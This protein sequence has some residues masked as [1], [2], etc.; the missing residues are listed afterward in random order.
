M[1]LS[2]V[3]HPDVVDFL[4]THPESSLKRSVWQCLEKLKKRQFDGGLRVKKLKGIAKGVWEAR[5]NQANRLT[6]TYEK[7][8]QPATGEKQVYLA[9]QDICL[10]HDDVS[11]SA[12]RVRNRTHDA[13][14][15][16]ADEVEVIGNLEVNRQSLTLTEQEALKK[17]KP[18]IYR[19][20]MMSSMNFS[21][22]FNG[23]SSSQ[24][25]NGNRQLLRIMPTCL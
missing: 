18:K 17:P 9:V 8:R 15:L 24:K 2:V 11:R 22:I 16:D 19:F 23:K 7:S 10:D 20:L 14:W 4:R 5:I 1:P 21:A 3:L 12:K 13:Q 6:Y 25:K